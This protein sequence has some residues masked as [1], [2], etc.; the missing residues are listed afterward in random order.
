MGAS[1]ACE[2]VFP[3]VDLQ[4]RWGAEFGVPIDFEAWEMKRTKVTL[5]FPLN[6]EPNLADQVVMPM[7]GLPLLATLVRDRGHDVEV[8]IER[9]GPIDWNRVAES[10][11]VGFT[12]ISPCWDRFRKLATQIHETWSIPIVVGGTF[13]TY[14]ADE[15]LTR[16]P[17]LVVV[18]G[19]GDETL[20]ELVEGIATGRDLSE[21]RGIAYAEDGEIV[22]T[23][24]RGY[25]SSF[26]TIPDY[27][28]VRGYDELA[29][30]PKWLAVRRR[31]LPLPTL[32]TSR[33]CPHTCSFC[34]V[35]RMFGSAY[36]TR[37][38]ESVLED[39]R[40]RRKYGDSFFIVDNYFTANPPRTKK[41]LESI[42]RQ[43]LG[44]NFLAFSRFE[45]AEDPEM[46][47][48]LRR[49][50]VRTLLIGFESL[51][52]ESL[53]SLGKG[54]DRTYIEGAVERLHA[55]R[56]RMFASF[57][58]GLDSD[59]IDSC[60]EIFDFARKARLDGF[61]IFPKFVMPTDKAGEDKK[62][63]IVEDWRYF[64]GNYVVHFPKNVKPSLLQREILR[65]HREASAG[66]QILRHLLQGRFQVAA[67]G[68]SLRGRIREL[69]RSVSG[70]LPLLEAA[71]RG[72]YTEEGRFIE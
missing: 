33:G 10:D 14:M 8:F 39:L 53:R 1:R 2:R 48:L 55:G 43:N 16:L 25:V 47:D 40:R 65:V 11:L 68:Q 71:E 26:E 57:I 17:F 70:Y 38:I 69:E 20:P 31:L 13:A 58:V 30:V 63:R 42:I 18:K 21:I 19:E 35:T 36:R 27:S 66:R 72:R 52:N 44:I 28:L 7:Y 41:L 24:E 32:Q 5:I 54:I 34:V 50:G 29:R 37:S 23:P 15:I 3:K 12:L 4:N 45:V 67:Q 56:I 6:P 22:H 62:R 49:A 59:T 60:Q 51:N 64:N 46:L 61:W 9:V